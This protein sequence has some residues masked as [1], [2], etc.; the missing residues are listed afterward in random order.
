MSE[1]RISNTTRATQLIRDCQG[2]APRTRFSMIPCSC[3]G[4]DTTHYVGKCI[5]CHTVNLTIP[6]PKPKV[7]LFGRAA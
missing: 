7:F 1:G 6:G 2:V 4:E 5:H 3:C